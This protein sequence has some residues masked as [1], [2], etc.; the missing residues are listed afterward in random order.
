[1]H[2]TAP[3]CQRFALGVQLRSRHPLASEKIGV[4]VA[5]A[6]CNPNALQ[7]I[8]HALVNTANSKNKQL[9]IGM[10]MATVNINSLAQVCSN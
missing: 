8:K 1:M 4:A 6:L 3:V 7:Y 5:D 9:G 10:Q 2:Q